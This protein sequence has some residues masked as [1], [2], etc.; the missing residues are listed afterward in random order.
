[1]CEM[2]IH[3]ALTYKQ[4]TVE[5]WESFPNIILSTTGF[6]LGLFGAR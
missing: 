2:S 4:L 1:M 6:K 5:I 3:V